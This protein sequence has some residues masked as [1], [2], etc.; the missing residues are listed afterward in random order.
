MGLRWLACPPHLSQAKLF[1]ENINSKGQA[2]KPG[3]MIRWQLTS[4]QV[5]LLQG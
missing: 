1:G 3:L 5:F 2:F 4:F